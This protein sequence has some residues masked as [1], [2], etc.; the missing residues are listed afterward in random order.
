MMLDKWHSIFSGVQHTEL[1]DAWFKNTIEPSQ[2]RQA[3]FDLG[4]DATFADKAMHG[5]G[6]TLM[7][8]DQAIASGGE[9]AAIAAPV[10]VAG[11]AAVGAATMQAPAAAAAVET[12]QRVLETTGDKKAAA[13]AGAT[14][15]LINA[16]SGAVPMGVGGNLATRLTTAAGAGVAM[17]EAGRVAQNAALPESMQQPFDIKED[18]LAAITTAP[19]GALG[20]GTPS[21]RRP[22]VE[23]GPANAMEQAQRDA[24]AHVAAQ[25]GDGL[26]QVVAATQVNAHIGAVHDAAAVQG[27]REAAVASREAFERDQAFEAAE[28]AKKPATTP[29]EGFQASEEQDAQQKEADFSKMQGDQEAAGAKAAEVGAEK[30][31]ANEPAPT[32]ADALPP[33]Q[34][35]AL[36]SLK[37]RRQV[38]GV[39]PAPEPTVQERMKA[40]AAGTEDDFQELPPETPKK[41]ALADNLADT[42][43]NRP[44]TKAQVPSE[45]AE[46]PEGNPPPVTPQTLA[47]RRQ[48]ALDEAMAAKVRGEPPVEAQKAQLPNE[49]PPA[50]P[51]R[52]AAIRA[53][54][55]KRAALSAPDAEKGALA[56][57]RRPPLRQMYDP[58]EE[59]MQAQ[60]RQDMDAAHG[61]ETAA[62][63]DYVQARQAGEEKARQEGDWQKLMGAKNVKAAMDVAD[64][65]P[66]G[67]AQQHLDRLNA[68]P[69]D[70]PDAR[71]A[72]E[73]KAA[74]DAKQPPGSFAERRAMSDRERGDIAQDLDRIANPRMSV[75]E[76]KE[77]LSNTSDS[78]APRAFQIHEAQ[79]SKT[80]PKGLADQIAAYRERNPDVRI[81]GA[82]SNGIAHIF[83]GSHNAGDK[84]QILNTA[85]HELA[86][87][88]TEGV[89]GAQHKPLMESL[90]RD[91]KD[92]VWART[93]AARRGYD[94]SNP[95]H[96]ANLGDEYVA[97]MAE[98]VAAG[99]AVNEG[100]PV[101]DQVAG[102]WQRVV[103]TVRQVLRKIGLVKHWTDND[104]AALIRQAQ[105]HSGGD[106]VRAGRD[107][108][109]YKDSGGARFSLDNQDKYMEDHFAPDHPNAVGHKL[110][111]TVEEQGKYNPGFVRDAQT[112]AKDLGEGVKPDHILGAIGLRNIP[113]FIREG[114][115]PN[116]RGFVEDHDAMEGRRR[117]ILNP[118]IDLA[119]EWSQWQAGQGDRGEALSDLMH[120]STMMGHDPSKP[121]VERHMAEERAASPEAAQD[122]KYQRAAHRS[123]QE[124]Y[125]DLDPKGQEIFNRVRDSYDDQRTAVM[126]GIEDRIAATG[127]DEQTKKNALS[128]LRKAFEAGK[129]KGAYFPLQRFGDL[130][131]NAKNEAG[132][133]ESFARFES[134]TQR[135][136]WLTEMR[137]LGYAVDSGERMDAKSEMERISPEFVK[138]VMGH[139]EAADPTGTL[140]KDV[141]QEYLKA[142]P[143]MSMRKHAIT[144][145][146]RLGFS[147]DALRAY[148]YNSF[149]GAHQLARLEYG[150]KLDTRMENIKNEARGVE[151]NA[152]ANPDDKQAQS[153]AK[154]APA[155]AR[156]MA[157]RY[158][159]L[160]NPRS[161]K[162]ASAMTRFGFSWYLGA[163][164]ATAFR[165]FSQNP[166]LA[167]PML[168]KHFGWMGATK[169]LT[170]ASM[171]W[172]AS[173][174]SL[175][176]RL[177]GDE[178]K[179][180][181]EADQRGVFSDTN[182]QTMAAGGDG[183]PLFKGPWYQFQKYAGFMFN[184]MEHHNRMTTLLAAYRLGRTQGAEHDD[185]SKQARQITWDSHF[186]YTNANRPRY[187]QGNVPKVIGLFKQ[188]SLG[189][190]Y[191][192]AR[193]GADLVNAEKTPE[194]RAAAGVALSSLVGRMMLFAGVTGVPGYWIAEKAIN[195]WMGSDDKPYDMTATLHKHLNDTLGQTA[196][197]SIMTGPVG[198]VSGAS[199][200]SGASYNDLWY[201]EPMRNENAKEEMFDALGQMLGPL[202]ALPI[203]AAQGIGQIHQGNVERGLEHFLPPE[204]AALA[205]AFRY[206]QE[207]ATNTAGQ[208]LLP[209]GEELT[210]KD[211]ALQA[212]GFTPQKVADAY[213]RNAAIKNAQQAIEDRRKVLTDKYETATLAGDSKTAEEMW[214]QIQKFNETNPGVA[215]GKSL[216]AG[217]LGKAKRNATAVQGV[218]L[219]PGLQNLQQEY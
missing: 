121:Y 49:E 174:G 3:D 185:A 149:H 25:G 2:E 26:A 180:F 28:A 40:Q 58:A 76:A 104:V 163:A 175:G 90:G 33:D 219:P 116:V 84:E 207:G 63:P 91:I 212:V 188:Y 119:K 122:E 41:G 133:T 200:S 62:V 158:D 162:L 166:M 59:L 157:S 105:A 1:Q 47:Q 87:K 184:A 120:A 80:V 31:G 42:A 102:H 44:P 27:A 5:I 103:D 132:E 52:L 173:K 129:V 216:A 179:A 78:S 161:S 38:A 123:L 57:R 152:A 34:R 39:E 126:K 66:R 74:R 15:Y 190:T 128:S 167:A 146:G 164:P 109:A 178:R 88:G 143:E 186:D 108:Q 192:L 194:E 99:R 137:K 95:N 83:A 36:E 71:K 19:F 35:A 11:R 77:H 213:K 209:P 61:P 112:L 56:E 142:M 55:E 127:A 60:V 138:N 114:K 6:A 24:A 144:R 208:N 195:A 168:A 23:A 94:L 43:D 169:E 136:Q 140:A 118:K 10:S 37:A 54:A 98:N 189:V 125:N 97:H 4:P 106:G 45:E 32:L 72:L 64:E 9:G 218:N 81:K 89:L 159:W 111:R 30:G 205:K 156:E 130:W 29:E 176:D 124:R 85:V 110:A 217:T 210:N 141:W 51:N 82:Y 153:D 196:G 101:K 13:I 14:S 50:P 20:H 202:A 199:L 67:E 206:S 147:G 181:D 145:V 8:I 177:R 69:G 131:A 204:A 148:A 53:A 215:I 73:S 16:A 172:A 151:S 75:A 193:E 211:L 79:D 171:Q 100:L 65:L 187:L 139:I 113:D 12:G 22:V 93:Y 201:K 86:H 107:G 182:T 115:M 160:R 7:A 203:N 150:Q 117:Q 134:R 96:V 68:A 191:R 135:K 170:R 70:N 46:A 183:S 197:D 155:I 18:A 92:T 165:I 48:A 198:A 214:P 21:V 154:W 17:Q